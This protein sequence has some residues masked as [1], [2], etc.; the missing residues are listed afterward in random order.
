MQTSS[1]IQDVKINVTA[2]HPSV[3]SN[4]PITCG[5][6]WPRGILFDEKLLVLKN[7]FDQVCQLQSSVLDR[8]KDG[9]I[10]WL[11]LDWKASLQDTA[12]YR[13]SISSQK[14]VV[15]LP[16]QITVKLSDET[17]SIDTGTGI[18]SMKCGKGSSVVQ[19]VTSGHAAGNAIAELMM[20]VVDEHGYH[21]VPWIKSISI[22]ERGNLRTTMCLVGEITAS[23][24]RNAL[25]NFVFRLH[26]F[27]GMNTV[28]F[29]TIIR[30]PRKAEHPGGLWDLGNGGSIYLRD[31]AIHLASTTVGESWS[32]KLSPE[33][34]SKIT[35]QNECELYQDSSG[36]ENWNSSNHVNRYGKVP[37]SF[38][39][40]RLRVDGE[41]STGLRATPSLVI[42]S[43][44]QTFGLAVPTFWQNFPLALEARPGQITLRLFPKQAADVHEIQGGEQKSHVCYLAF[45]RDE[46]SSDTLAWCHSPSHAAAEPEWYSNSGVVPYLTPR[47]GDPHPEYLQLVDAALEGKDTFAKKRE[48]IDE[49]GWRHFGEIY[50][51]HEAVLHKG[52]TPL[53]SHYNN[54]Y[55]AVAGLAYQYLRST[56]RR[57]L[58]EMRHLAQHVI[59]IDIYHT[60]Q[61]KSAYNHGLFWH[62]FHYVDAHTG[63]HRS[64]PRD[65]RV[66]PDG[67]PVPGGGPANEQNYTTGLMLNY[68]LTGHRPSREAAIGLAQWVIDM[69]DGSKTIFRWLSRS[70][71]GLASKSLTPFY[72][73]PG[74]GGANS[75]IALIDGHRLTDEK[76]FL[77]KAEQLVRR[78]IHPSDD[79]ARRNLLDAEERWFYTM[80]L[81]SLGRYLQYKQELGELDAMYAYAQASLLHYVRWMAE[82]EYPYLDKPE[83][84]VYPTETWAAQD[85]RKCEIFNLASLYADM[86]EMVRF[87]E[88]ADYFFRYSTSK[89]LT[90][91]TRTFCRPV[92]LMLSYGFAHT[93]FKLHPEA[94]ALPVKE[95]T[96]FGLPAVFVPQKVIAIKRAKLI[97]VTSAVVFVLAIGAIAYL[98]FG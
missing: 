10:R 80:F 63:T 38:R 44:T 9:S 16:Q 39:G 19:F 36:G 93:W 75:I 41:E 85:M 20:E 79:V 59:D 74:R 51:D 18:F 48:V 7:S 64:Y 47:S 30:N 95:T 98:L 40:Y 73:G 70:Y 92:V 69:D 72:H 54:Q 14:H 29:E 53:I 81:Q 68:F 71:T 45:G 3:R 22:E 77:E 52:P 43:E 35:F 4:E 89:L 42:Q 96:D 21:Y 5:I 67:H 87:R 15:S 13:L 46:V 58:I 56:D 33:Q 82:H 90:M 86:D 76:R 32:G 8:W 65:A 24:N 12:Q 25:A 94:K 50:G 6:P 55:D 31:V 62:T 61:D 27:A 78:C 60:D 57:W 11:L 88:K 91:P 37:L 1:Q 97:I 28:R 84:L 2:S 49:Y 17:T 23:N 26:F 34:C 83:I 66:P